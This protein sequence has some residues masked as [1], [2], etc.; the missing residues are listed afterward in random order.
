[1]A[2]AIPNSEP[3]SCLHWA[4]TKLNL[5]TIPDGKG[6][7]EALPVSAELLASDEFCVRATGQ[8]V[9]IRWMF[10]AHGHSCGPS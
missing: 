6:A 8:P 9:R 2:I 1:M 7:N 4:G 5:R 10:H 3:L